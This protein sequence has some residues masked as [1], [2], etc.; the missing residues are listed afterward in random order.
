MESL[1][2]ESLAGLAFDLSQPPLEETIVVHIDGVLAAG[3]TYDP[4]LN[5]IVFNSAPPDGSVIDIN[6][7]IIG[8]CEE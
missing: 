7:A 4:V 5:R 8:E 1:A 3:W 6:Y 2:R